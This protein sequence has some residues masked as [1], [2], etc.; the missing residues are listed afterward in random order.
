[1]NWLDYIL[2]AFLALSL[3]TSARKGFAREVIGLAAAILAL[4]FGMWFYGTA[5]LLV[6]PFTGPGRVASMLG[7][8]LIFVAV[9]I[10]GTL[11]GWV[12]KR[13]LSAVGLSVFD[14]LLGAVFGLARGALIATAVLTAYM[15]FGSHPAGQNAPAAVVNSKLAPYLLEA[16]RVFVSIAPM[17]LK[18][19]FRKEYEQVKAAT[20]DR[21]SGGMRA[22]G[23]EQ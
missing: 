23:S 6:E 12:V 22:K 18:S 9:L 10:A 5:G 7:F 21:A 11:L 13:F 4:V 15:A 19:G 16:S 8:L 3:L 17:D 2:A 20:V 1:V 14:R